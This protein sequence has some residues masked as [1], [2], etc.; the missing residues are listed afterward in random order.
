MG[1]EDSVSL[2][3]CLFISATSTVSI[4]PLCTFRRAPISATNILVFLA[5]CKVEIIA[6]KR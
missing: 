1:A 4:N 5:F 6:L 3:K 2:G